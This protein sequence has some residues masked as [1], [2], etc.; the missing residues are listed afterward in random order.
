MQVALFATCLVDLLP[1]II[2][3]LVSAVHKRFRQGNA[4][5]NFYLKITGPVPVFP[6]RV[7]IPRVAGPVSEGVSAAGDISLQAVVSES[8]LFR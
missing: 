6:V 5:L 7:T 4:R 2:I 3:L 1:V 8:G